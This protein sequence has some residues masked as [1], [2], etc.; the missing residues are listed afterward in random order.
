M[1]SC[2]R[3]SPSPE[4]TAALLRPELTAEAL[5]LTRLLHEHLPSSGETA[6]LLALMLLQDSRRDTRTDAS[7]A[8]VPLAEQDRSRWDSAAIAEGVALVTRALSTGPAGPYQVQA[9]IAAVHA[10]APT[11]EATDWVQVVGLYD[12]LERL[13]PNPMA[14][15]NRAVA[16]GMARGPQAGLALVE[17]LAAGPLAGHHRLAAVRA[18]LLE[19]AGDQVQAA[20]AYRTAA[21]FATNVR[22]QRFLAQR[23]ARLEMPSGLAHR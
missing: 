18:H 17:E 4:Y 23:A 11:S 22:E 16:V 10:E 14:S 5:R 12:A 20:G 3:C 7:G 6:G 8:L 13:A 21:R 2:H 9:A 19:R 15:L 1:P